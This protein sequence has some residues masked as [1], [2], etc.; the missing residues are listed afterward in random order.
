MDY[1][2]TNLYPVMKLY[3]ITNTSVADPNPDPDPHVFRPPESGSISQ[4]HGSATLKNTLD[5]DK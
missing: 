1:G 5:F 3:G 2:F 4:R